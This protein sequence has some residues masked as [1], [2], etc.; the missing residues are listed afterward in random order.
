MAAA[1]WSIEDG[2][3]SQS[4][5]EC[6]STSC[7]RIGAHIHGLFSLPAPP[8]GAFTIFNRNTTFEPHSPQINPIRHIC[9]KTPFTNL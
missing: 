6:L 7:R 8:F 3:Q 9:D 4:A 1:V 5:Y 2:S